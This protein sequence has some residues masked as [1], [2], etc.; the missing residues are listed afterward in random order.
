MSGAPISKEI[1]HPS[2]SSDAPIWRSGGCP[3]QDRPRF[4]GG[5]RL[6]NGRA[7]SP[8]VPVIRES[9]QTKSDSEIMEILEAFDLSRCAESAGQL[10]HGE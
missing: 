5:S 9:G 10:A 2:Q 3:D 6:H 4:T 1:R 8:G 7:W